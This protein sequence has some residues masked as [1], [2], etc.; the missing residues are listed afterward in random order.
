LGLGSFAA[1]YLGESTR[2]SELF[3]VKALFKF[4]LTAAQVEAHRVEIESLC[5]VAGHPYVTTLYR[6]VDEEDIT[7]LIME[8]C[9]MDLYETIADSEED[10]NGLGEEESKRLF[11]QIVDAVAF[12]Q[13]KGVWHRDLKPENVLLG[14][15]G[16]VR[17]A[18]FGLSHLS[19]TMEPADVARADIETTLNI[20]SLRYEA[21]ELLN[22][23]TERYLPSRADVWSLGIILL[24]C[25]RGKSPWQEASLND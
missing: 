11:A 4:G 9:P 25:L 21:P 12:S 22:Y 18:D 3:A 19:R 24:N 15:D 20:G 8:Y 1:V 14:R 16:N 23:R 2:T 17:L 7:W 6:V 5:R 13:T 10:G